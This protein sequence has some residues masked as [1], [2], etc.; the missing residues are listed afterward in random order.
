MRIST[1]PRG[2]A[3]LLKSLFLAT[4]GTAALC[5]GGTA[6]AQ[7]AQSQDQTSASASGADDTIVVTGIRRSLQDSVSAKRHAT[8]I[9]EA[10][11]AEDIGKL[12]DE[13]IAD[14]LTRLPGLAGQRVGGR[15]QNLSIRGLSPDFSATLLDGYQQ[16]STGD[17]RSAEFDQYPSELVNGATVY[18]TPDVSLVGQG[19]AGT[20]NLTTLN[21]LD[22]T[23][24]TFAVN[25]RGSTNSLGSQIP[26]W[27]SSGNRISGAYIDQFDNGK[28]GVAI[29][30]AHLDAPEQERWYQTWYWGTPPGM[31]PAHASAQAVQGSDI[32]GYSRRV[33]RDGLMATVEFRP[34]DTFHSSNT[35]FYSQFR[36]TEIMRGVNWIMAGNADS[37]QTVT[38]PVFQTIGT[39][40]FN[41]GGTVNEIVPLMQSY[42]NTRN[43]DEL[44]FISRNTWDLSNDWRLGGDVS[45][46]YAKRDEM[47]IQEYG[48]YGSPGV[49]DTVTYSNGATTDGFP[50]FHPGLNYADATK[51]V[52][53]CPSPWGGCWGHDGL[54]HSPTTKDTFEEGKLYARHDFSGDIGNIFSDVEIGIDYSDRNKDKTENDLNLYLTGAYSGGVFDP[55]YTLP[56]PSNLVTAPVDLSWGGWGPIFGYDPKAALSLYTQVPIQD[57]NQYDKEWRVEED[58]TTA[59]FKFD[60][61]TQIAGIPVEGN[62]GL[63]YVYATQDSRGFITQGSNPDGT[64]IFAPY[65]TSVSYGETLPSLNLRFELPYD[66]LVRFGV[67]REMSRPR[68]DDLRANAS[69]GVGLPVDHSVNPQIP[70]TPSS[71]NTATCYGDWSGSGG[72][73]NLRPWLATSYD[74]SYE[75]YFTAD[76]AS[77]FAMAYYYKDFSTYIFTQQ[78]NNY[79]FAGYPNITGYPTNGTSGVFTLPANGTGGHVDGVE[80][81]GTLTGKLFF[82]DTWLSGFG[83]TGSLS[84]AWTNILQNGPQTLPDGTPN[85]FYDPN[86]P[87]AGLSGKVTSWTAFYEHYGFSARVSQRYRSP[88]YAD[89]GGLF[90][91]INRVEIGADR[92]TDA[93]LSY[94]LPWVNGLTLLVQGYNLTNEPYIQY[95]ST[96]P[97]GD[98]TNL[99]Y[100]QEYGRTLLFGFNYKW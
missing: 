64:A 17:N 70:C 90:A 73:P 26:G 18:K 28:L 78:N 96:V 43:D 36:Q 52:L 11:S 77:Y 45:Y 48:Q 57:S 35:L 50:Q 4:V 80:F 92:T 25:V 7:Q 2:R 88:Y 98:P 79:N 83:V 10:I 1:M 39:T 95:A 46:S 12:P 85:G 14:A 55:N 49:L 75:K 19:L 32:Y 40:D 16:A 6:L 42:Y 13:S 68:L 23:K 65:E 22:L 62:I 31:P 54:N 9:V 66:Q 38:N 63:Q 59:Y 84:R 47:Q 15:Y 89:V 37:S 34:D 5:A 76:P 33:K 53:D 99:K 87:L 21:P 27:D 71:S 24:R 60:I 74:I 94:D 30:L 41:T 97:N 100:R 20:V 51:I 44:S 61:R 8:E 3:G 72:N 56:L 93:Q 58:L 86:V 69:A 82:G 91:G 29:G 81:S 67:A